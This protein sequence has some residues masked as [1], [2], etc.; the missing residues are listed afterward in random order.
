MLAVEKGGLISLKNDNNGLFRIF[1]N[2]NMYLSLS[3]V[4]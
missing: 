4:H 3:Q 1:Y 2:K